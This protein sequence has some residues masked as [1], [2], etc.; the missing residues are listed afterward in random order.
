MTWISLAMSLS[1]SRFFSSADQQDTGD[2]AAE[3]A[4]AAV[5]V[6]AAE[7]DGRR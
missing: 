7:Q 6:D 3:R 2:R 4:L 5:E 1:V